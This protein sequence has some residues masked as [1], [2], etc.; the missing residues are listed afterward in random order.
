MSEK[1]HVAALIEFARWAISESS[2]QGCNLDGGD[3]QD[4]AHELGLLVEATI[5]EP[6]SE[7]HCA[8]ADAGADFPTTCFRF[9]G[10]LVR[11]GA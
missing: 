5:A 9:A 1:E 4:K 10:P 3:I 11:N 7:E 2:F 8:C 6:C